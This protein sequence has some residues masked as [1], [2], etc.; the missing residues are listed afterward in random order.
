[1][2]AFQLNG[3]K[4]IDSIINKIATNIHVFTRYRKLNGVNLIKLILNIRAS[5]L[6]LEIF[7]TFLDVNLRTTASTSEQQKAKLQPEC[8]KEIMLEPS[9]AS[10]AAAG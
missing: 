6:N 2:K 1:M 8:F 5:S 10:I 9:Q 3:L 4:L 7:H